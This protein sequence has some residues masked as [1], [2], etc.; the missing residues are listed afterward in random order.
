MQTTD[1]GPGIADVKL[2]LQAG[3]S[4]APQEARDMGFGAGMGLVNIRRCVDRMDL[5]STLG[6]GTK[7]LMEINL[8]AEEG[9]KESEGSVTP[10]STKETK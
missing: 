8:R 4:T 5:E 2:A 1:T 6:K 3:W 7:L 10:N 9:F